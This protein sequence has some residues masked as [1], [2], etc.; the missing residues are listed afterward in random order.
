[1]KAA[2]ILA[3]LMGLVLGGCGATVGSIPPPGGEDLGKRRALG[4][5]LPLDTLFLEDL[6]GTRIP[7]EEWLGRDVIV[8]TF[9]ATF[10]KPCK[11]EMPF[12]QRLHQ[13]HGENGLRVLAISLDTPDTESGVRPLIQR[14]RYTFTVTVDR[15]SDATRL[16][17]SKSILPHLVII[18][19]GGRVALCKDGFTIGDQAAIESLVQELLS[20]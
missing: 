16:M 7:L 8:V 1:M 2:Q 3:L 9:W 6:S 4:A 15:Q 18:D 11:A 10:C 14:N 19:R 13:Q 17:N 12:L 5:P 20:P